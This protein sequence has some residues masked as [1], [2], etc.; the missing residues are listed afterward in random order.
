MHIMLALAFFTLPVARGQAVERSTSFVASDQPTLTL[1]ADGMAWELVR[2][3][4]AVRLLATDEEGHT[5][6]VA[7]WS[8]DS[9]TAPVACAPVVGGRVA[10]ARPAGSRFRLTV[11]DVDGT[12][13]W[14]PLT[15][16]AR[17]DLFVAHPDLPFVLVRMPRPDGTA[18]A[19][20][21]D[22]DTLRITARDAVPRGDDV[23]F[24]PGPAAWLDGVPFDARAPAERPAPTA[25]PFDAP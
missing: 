12:E 11:R 7:R 24:G 8:P 10:L 14:L 22:I 2:A 13:T 15:L 1:T 23:R 9:P 25:Y 16:P 19:W 18:R 20:W 4:D 5:I 21:V 6:T 3:P 17:P